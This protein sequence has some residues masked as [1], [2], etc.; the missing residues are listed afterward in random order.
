[1]TFP[2]PKEELS[3]AI[4]DISSGK[5]PGQDG[6]LTEVFKCGGSH[7]LDAL[8][9]LLCTCWDEG[10]V[11]QETRDSTNTTLYKNKGDHSNRNNYRYI[12]VP[13]LA[14]KLFAQEALHRL[15]KLA[16]M[17]YP[18]SQCGFRSKRST[19]DMIFLLRQLQV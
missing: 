5:A 1:M 4:A 18:E 19:V 7:L 14:G 12:S 15:Q 6:I 17:V 8:H 3:K 13:C 10:S 11:S 9:Q 16:E 2:P